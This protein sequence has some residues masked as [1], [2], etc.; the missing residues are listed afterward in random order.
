M[1]ARSAT[2]RTSLLS[3]GV[4]RMNAGKWDDAAR[5]FKRALKANRRDPDALHLLGLARHGAG[6]SKDAIKYIKRAIANAAGNQ[7]FLN[8][9]G[10]IYKAVGEVPK[11]I[12]CFRRAIA[13][14]G[15]SH[16][17]HNNLANA[18]S[19]A[20]E[21]A[22][23]IEH[24]RLA[25]AANPQYAV[26]HYNLG[27][28]HLSRD[29]NDEADH[30]FRRALQ[31]APEYAEAHNNL[32]LA[33]ENREKLE[34]ANAA[35]RR[36]LAINPKFAEAHY[37]LGNTLDK[38]NKIREAVAS[39]RRALSIRPVYVEALNNLGRC[40]VEMGMLDEAIESYRQALARWP[41]HAEIR[42]NLGMTLM[43]V[44]RF[45]EGWS[46][47]E[48]RWLTAGNKRKRKHPWPEWQG[49]DAAGKTI[50]IWG[51]Q[52]VGDEVRY[53]AMLPDLVEQGARVV[54]ECEARLVPLF[55][56]SFAGVTCIAMQDPPAV[57]ARARDIDF[58]IPTGSLGRWLRPD[59]DSF[60]G[61]RSYLAADPARRDALRAKYRQRGDLVVGV[62][63]VSK[64]PRFGNRKSMKLCDLAPIAAVRGSTLVDL[65]YGDTEAERRA[66]AEQ[67][68]VT[69]VHDDSVDQMKDLDAFAAQVAAMDLVITVSNTTAHVAGAL[70]VPAWVLL[71]TMPLDCWMLHREDSPWYP[72][73]RL[74][75]QQRRGEW[76]ELVGRVAEALSLLAGDA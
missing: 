72:S 23:A 24:Y 27:R 53:A 21:P 2:D 51:E 69:L 38:Q 26:A 42:T 36:A 46:E 49:T 41:D 30:C 71:N 47:Y 52:G 25:L 67:T 11:A 43:R 16:E 34:D 32:G 37:N 19:E 58:Q 57:E 15:A 75:R 4:E 56:R 3:A 14:D 22:A 61:R 55:R 65:Q 35:Y 60:P 50:L 63:W 68:G 76:A 6:H 29:N 48:W 20:G 44:G 70:G 45:A 9:L 17:A 54:L 73:V 18:L 66:F 74:F 1:T 8:N 62:A 28:L 7:Q 59:F 12:D 40:L 64:N 33:L 5:F 31:I 13:I 10:Q 39:Y